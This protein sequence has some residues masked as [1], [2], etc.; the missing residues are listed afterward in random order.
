MG[1]DGTLLHTSSIFQTSCPPVLS[2]ALGSLGFLTPY[3]FQSHEQVLEQ[4]LAGNVAVILRSRVSCK[5]EKD[6]A[7]NNSSLETPQLDPDPES[8]AQSSD[9]EST[10]NPTVYS[11]LALNEVVIDRGPNSYLSNLDLYINDRFITK[12]Q[13]D[14]KTLKSLRLRSIDKLIPNLQGLIISTP[15]GSTAYAM[16]GGFRSD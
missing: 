12:V 4:V 9:K 2:F 11:H 8:S 1:G 10:T 15:T 3:D 6:G 13:G 14:G 5:I 7:E 16:A